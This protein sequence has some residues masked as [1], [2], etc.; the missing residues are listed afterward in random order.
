MNECNSTL[1]SLDQLER[2][3]RSQ[4]VPCAKSR[5]KQ[6]AKQIASVDVSH[7][8][9]GQVAIVVH[10]SIQRPDDT[11]RIEYRQLSNLGLCNRGEPVGIDL[12]GGRALSVDGS[13]ASLALEISVRKPDLALATDIILP[14]VPLPERRFERS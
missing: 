13:L 8:I 1:Q 11:G 5:W 10:K 2:A 14:H 4:V 6:L 12:V 9:A 7:R 3:V